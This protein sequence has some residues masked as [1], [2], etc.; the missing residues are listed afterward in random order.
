MTYTAPGARDFREYG[1][2]LDSKITD[3]LSKIASAISEVEAGSSYLNLVTPKI[4]AFTMAGGAANAFSFAWANT[5]G[6][7]LAI[8]K[9]Y[10]VITTPGGT[11]TSVLDIG[12]GATATTHSDNLI[13][14]LDAN[15]AAVADNI[16]NKGTNGKTSAIMAAGEY[17]TG[18]ILTANAAALVGKV[19]IEYMVI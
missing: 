18:Q 1:G 16:T 8:L 11:A 9:V 10:A 17:I 3:E 7:S 15:A 12:I 4:A 19:V 14:G 5:T 2:D 13:D 6:Y